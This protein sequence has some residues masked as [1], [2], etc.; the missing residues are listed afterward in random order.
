MICSDFGA[1]KIEFF[2]PPA[3]P[4]IRISNQLLI[5]TSP[6]AVWGISCQITSSGC[7]RVQCTNEQWRA[8]RPQ[9]TWICT[10]LLRS[11]GSQR[12]GGD[13]TWVPSPTPSTHSNHT[14]CPAK[15]TQGL[16]RVISHLGQGEQETGTTEG[17]RRPASV[18][19][20]MQPRDSL[21]EISH[22]I[23][24][25]WVFQLSLKGTVF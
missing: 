5:C 1:G 16:W 23:L 2:S 20:G 9:W 11:L 3:I 22:S 6:R 25:D 17:V 12:V 7:S 18:A 10:E 4:L 15:E 8:G 14:Q 21:S 24:L 13:Q 19:V